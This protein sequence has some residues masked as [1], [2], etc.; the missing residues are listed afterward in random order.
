M[1]DWALSDGPDLLDT[2]G[3]DSVAAFYSDSGRMRSLQCVLEQTDMSYA[4]E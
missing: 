4:L 3:D 2:R 1:G